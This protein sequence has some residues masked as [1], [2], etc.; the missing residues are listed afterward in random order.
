MNHW[1]DDAIFYHLFPLGSTGAPPRNDFVSSPSSRLNDLHVWLPYLQGLGVNALLLGPVLESGAHGYDTAYLSTVDRR[2]GTNDD[3]RAFVAACHERGVRVVLDAV[4]NHVGRE[5]WA[6]RDVRERGSESPYRDWFFL[7]FSERSPNGD[8]FGYRGWDGHFDLVKLN[9]GNTEVREH[10]FGAARLWLQDFGFD[11]LRLDAADVLE[12]GFRQDLSAFCREVKPDVWLLGEV[13]HGDY[14][15]WAGPEKSDATTNYEL[16]TGLFS[17]HNDRNYFEVAYALGRQFGAAGVYRG[18]PLYAFADNHDV[19]RVASILSDPAHLYP[20][21]I[22]LLSAPG[23]PSLYYGSEWGVLGRKESGSDA[24]LRPALTPETLGR[25]SGQVGAH[26]DLYGVVKA[27]VGL[28]H[29]LPALR[30]GDYTERL[31]ASEQFAFTRRW[32]GET[33]LAVVNASNGPVPV[34]VPGLDG[35]WDDLLNPGETFDAAVEGLELPLSPNWGR[36]LR[37][38]P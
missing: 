14:R 30:H 7:D 33:V 25:E 36:V 37:R 27:L 28:R 6:F 18:L 24:A 10:L 8:P 5:F 15:E 13:V 9:T 38:R 3:L 1:A 16:Y 21:H 17:S 32:E 2:L 31:V 34:T 26:P 22:L 29:L 12:P 20:L 19:P 23:V 35:T 11:G 4:F